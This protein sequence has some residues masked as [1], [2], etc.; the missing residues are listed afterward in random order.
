[1]CELKATQFLVAH[2]M[3][4]VLR[5][6]VSARAFVKVSEGVLVGVDL[7]GSVL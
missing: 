7:L 1:M 3:P 6:K 4:C 5:M 2:T